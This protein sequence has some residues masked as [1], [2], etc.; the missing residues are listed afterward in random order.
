MALPKE[1]RQKMINLMYL[2]L[3]A[4][5]ALN[6]SSE[7]L[8]AFKVVDK[9]LMTSNSNLTVASSN[10][11]RSLEDMVADPKTK[12]K[13]EIWKPKADQVKELSAKLNDYIESLKTDLKKEAGLKLDK[14]GN[15]SFKEDDLEAATRLFSS[16]GSGKKKGAEMLAKL[17][18][19][20]TAMLAIDPSIAKKFESTFPVTI[21][22]TVKGQDGKMKKFEDAYFHMTPTVAALT[23]LSKFQNNVKNAENQVAT[24]CAEQVGAVKVHFDQF[25]P[26][27]GQ[28]STY[29][30]PGQE[31]TIT[32]GLGAYSKDVLPSISIGGSPAPLGPNGSAERKFSASGAGEQTVSVVVNYVDQDGNPKSDTRQIKYTV[33]QPSGAAVFL[34]K[35]NVFYIGVDNP[36]TIGSSAGWDKTSVSMTG[37]SISGSGDHRMVRVNTPGAASITVTADGKSSTFNFRVLRIPDPV[38]KV[39]SLDGLKPNPSTV[40]FKNA[41]LCFAALK[42]FLFDTRFSVVSAD[43][44]FYGGANFQNPVRAKMTG[45]SFSSISNYIS[46]CSPGSSVSFT[47]IVVSG[48]DGTRT[49]E[50]GAF[51][52]Q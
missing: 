17:K 51:Q 23:L 7:I 39:G 43:V 34:D 31:V 40:A 30:M 49:I 19:Y 1:P 12:T 29:V 4:L 15:E 14:N 22:E 50:G 46:K 27:I 6:V 2:V 45:P 3:T 18:E 48:P 42:D 41:S 20:R 47:N 11:Y 44:M 38:F 52:L 25:Q 35:M 13:A 33:G 36:I 5:L 10:V 26:I 37:G 21:E 24:Y 8:N 32:A 9:S 16:E 28:S